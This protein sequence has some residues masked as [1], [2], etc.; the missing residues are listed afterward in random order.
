MPVAGDPG[1]PGGRLLLGP[2]GRVL[3]RYDDRTYDGRPR[4]DLL[5]RISSRTRSR[6]GGWRRRSR[7]A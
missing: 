5:E 2:G 4:A 3:A 6:P 1:V 7:P